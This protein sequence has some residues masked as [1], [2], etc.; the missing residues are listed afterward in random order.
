MADLAE[1]VTYTPEKVQSFVNV[2][3]III[4]IF[5]TILAL[6]LIGWYFFIRFK[7]KYRVRMFKKIGET[8]IEYQDNAALVKLDG[9]YMFHYRATKKYSPV[10]SSE[11]FRIM[12]GKI[13]GF[14]PDNKQGF[15]AYL[16]GESIFPI[17]V[18]KNPGLHP[19]NIDLFNYMEARVK[20]NAAKYQRQNLLL[21]YLPYVGIGAIVIMFIIG[22]IFYTQHIERVSSMILDKTTEATTLLTNIGNKAQVI[23]PR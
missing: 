23:P 14:I 21:Q 20:A 3:F 11:F 15:S 18:M 8:E 12:A 4:L 5:L 2:L 16:D 10:V 17:K 7:Y 1:A 22:M 9:N 6:G 13:L 19:I